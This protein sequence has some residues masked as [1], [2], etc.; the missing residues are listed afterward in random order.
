MTRIVLSALLKPFKGGLQAKA[1][2]FPD[3][4]VTSWTIPR[5]ARQA[6]REALA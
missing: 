3:L 1:A 2:E 5:R 6:A 4:E